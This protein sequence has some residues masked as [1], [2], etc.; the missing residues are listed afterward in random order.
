VTV[1]QF[2]FNK[3]TSA[4]RIYM[5][6]AGLV[7]FLII[8]SAAGLMAQDYP[9]CLMK[10]QSDFI[11]RA[12]AREN[13]TEQTAELISLLNRLD[14]NYVYL[15][16]R[17][18]SGRKIVV[19]IDPAH[20][21]L[22]SGRWQGEVT[23]RLSATGL[24]EEYYSIRLSRQLYRVLSSNPYIEVRSTDDFMKALR[25]ETDD[26]NNIPFSETVRLANACDAF[27]ILSEHLNNVSV[28]YKAGGHANIPGIHVIRYRNGVSIL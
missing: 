5:K 22:P 18:Q 9:T 26:Y 27:I 8:I 24:P 13:R 3:L 15:H 2:L 6:K 19:F 23:E 17:L 28:I 16:E 4:S 10:E 20:G 14:S 12:L 1:F 21:R 11:T 7:L 25:G